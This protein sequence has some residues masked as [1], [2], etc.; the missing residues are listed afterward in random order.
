M[1]AGDFAR[2]RS[3]FDQAMDLPPNDR[4]A[5]LDREVPPGDP[6]RS[7]LVA[8]VEAGDD[9]TFL[10]DAFA[11]G[12]LD[13]ARPADNELPSQIG[14]YKIL[15][16]LGKG[17]MG[18]VF[19]ALR[20]DDVFHKVVALKVIGDVA[21][22]P[23]M[24]LVERFKQERQ[25][26]AGLD[27]P[28]IARILDGGNT[29]DGRPFYVMEY[30]PGSPID[31]YCVQM[32]VDVPTRVRMMAQVCD[33][34]DYLH[35]N[36]IA[37]RDIKPQN[38]LVTLDGRVKL[39]DFG[40]AKVETVRGVLRSTPR[41]EP[42]M[43]MTP[44][45]ASPEQI[46]G[47]TSG[48]SGDVYSVAAVLYQ[49]LTGRLPHAD[50]D[51]RPNLA[52]R[53]LGTP[54]APPSKDLTRSSRPHAGQP[55]SGKVS[56]PDLDR[57]VLTALQR[58]PR[59]RYGTV[60]LFGDDLRRC[61]DR[62]PIS[63]RAQT[64]TYTTRK[65]IE[66]NPVISAIAAAAVIVALAGGWMG[67][68]AYLQRVELQAKQEQLSQFVAAFAGKVAG[69]PG[70]ASSATEKV[71]DMRAAN[72][73]LASDTVRTLSERAPD[74]PR[75]KR[76]FI[77]LRNV[78]D[79]ADAASRGEPAL[80]K[81]IALVYR[82]IGDVESRAPLPA[83][84]D[85]Q[86]AA[87]SYQRAAVIAADL[88]GADDGWASQQLTE[89]SGLLGRLGAPLGLATETTAAVETAAAV[90][91]PPAPEPT[92][93][94]RA[95]AATPAITPDTGAGDSSLPE[96]DPAARAEIEQR[97]RSTRIDAERARRNFE[98]LRNSLASSGQTI[99]GNVEGFLTEAESLIEDARGGLEQNDLATAEDYL[100][101]ASYQL[102][103]VFQAVGG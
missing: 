32:H 1:T 6:R 54:P 79:R 49:L 17:G 68:N 80:R 33:A 45:Y 53:L 35:A 92:V 56:F 38:I 101:R 14:H 100:R 58:D 40:I 59:Q 96:V 91:P 86:Q 73:L 98:A 82:R 19:L 103:R 75:V 27:H 71:A 16:R 65:A 42:T 62:R 94:T 36:A 99:R 102:K 77:E 43:I 28:N 46:A 93:S 44:G 37:H 81:E 24:N 72:E 64:V 41:A 52:A 51:G 3:L 30:V 22:S 89:L 10:A 97:L 7:E 18:V 8:M 29:N 88:R 12:V 31:E 50:R 26:L 66:R 13:Q 83:I 74:P 57:V 67:I 76:L 34:V 95:R 20:N 90:A 15:R 9:S 21:D 60:Q 25:I 87:R 84:A 69:W 2:V 5:F 4:R 11:N 78:L 61:L 48:K 55:E 85:K 23:E 39:V 47:E 70:G 63:A